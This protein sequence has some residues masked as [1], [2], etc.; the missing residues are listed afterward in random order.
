MVIWFKKRQNLR[1]FYL[2]FSVKEE[3]EMHTINN[4]INYDNCIKFWIF[5]M[6]SMKHF[7]KFDLYVLIFPKSDS[8][9]FQK[10]I[11][12]LCEQRNLLNV[13][14]VQKII[15]DQKLHICIYG[16]SA[17]GC[18]SEKRRLCYCCKPIVKLS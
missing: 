17:T 16:N 5:S 8:L 7:K 9:Y 2:I 4:S 14:F 3:K 15:F 13:Q 11:I 10:I 1:F 18:E 6:V 12:I